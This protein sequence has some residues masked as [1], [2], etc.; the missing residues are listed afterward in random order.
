MPIR[1]KRGRKRGGAKAGGVQTRASGLTGQGGRGDPL[2]TVRSI[3]SSSEDPSSSEGDHDEESSHPIDDYLE[4][5]RN[6]RDMSKDTILS[7][8]QQ[9]LSPERSPLEHEE[10][11]KTKNKIGTTEDYARTEYFEKREDYA[12]TEQRLVE[13][14]VPKQ[15]TTL[16]LPPPLE[17]LNKVPEHPLD[18]IVLIENDDEMITSAEYRQFSR[19]TRYFDDDATAGSTCFKCGQVGHIAR[20]CPN[21]PKQR[22]CFLCAGFGHTSSRCPNS[23]CFRCGQSGHMVR[24]CL[25]KFDTWENSNRFLCRRCGTTHCRAA[26]PG[27]LLRAEGKCD[28]AYLDDDLRMIT[29]LACGEIG[30]ANCQ[31]L[32]GTKPVR[33]CFNCGEMGH[34]GHECKVGPTAPVF[35]ERKRSVH[36]RQR[37]HQSH[38]SSA[39][40]RERPRPMQR[41]GVTNTWSKHI[42]H[43]KHEE[44]GLGPMRRAP[45][46]SGHEKHYRSGDSSRGGMRLWRR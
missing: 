27:D 41:L 46:M 7:L 31:Q 4:K 24:D 3:Q 9:Q 22:P 23:P 16:S 44:K 8:F 30:H 11:F 25:E 45:G 20:D 18:G 32:A 5:T 37:H 12:T 14:S 43:R 21:P 40:G 38:T 42:G 17:S 19:P 2:A 1:K 13:K 39:N 29:C 15:E 28:Q 34:I 33:S 26:G 35:A 10:H 6:D 36:H